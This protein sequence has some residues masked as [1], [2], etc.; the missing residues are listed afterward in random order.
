[1]IAIFNYVTKCG[2]GCWLWLRLNR[3]STYSRVGTQIT[4]GVDPMVV[5]C[6]A[7]IA[8][9]GPTLTQHR[10]NVCCL[11]TL[12]RC[13]INVSCLLWRDQALITMITVKNGFKLV[14]FSRSLYFNK[15]G[16]AL[17]KN[18][19]TNIK[20]NSSLPPATHTRRQRIYRLSIY[21]ELVH[22]TNA[23]RYAQCWSNVWPMLGQHTCMWTRNSLSR[24]VI[25]PGCDWIK[26]YYISNRQHI[27]N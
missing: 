20:T 8:E 18:L 16:N 3:D 5:Y 12:G 25:M 4:R 11:Q 27:L 14:Q 19:K 10:V 26:I 1:M 15:K 23:M 24:H 17:N 21:T 7:C 6:W 13:C 22:S 2:V 9:S